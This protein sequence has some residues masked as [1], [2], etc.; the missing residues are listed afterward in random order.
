MSM[1]T[2]ASGYAQSTKKTANENV[3]TD[4]ESNLAE[5]SSQK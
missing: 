4:V 1:D 3:G 5:S 2:V